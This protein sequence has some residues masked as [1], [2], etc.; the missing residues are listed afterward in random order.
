MSSV[1]SKPAGGLVVFFDHSMHLTA[2]IWKRGSKQTDEFFERLAA[3]D[4]T[5]GAR[6]KELDVVRQNLVRYFESSPA[7]YLVGIELHERLALLLNNPILL[8]MGDT[9]T[10]NGCSV[11]I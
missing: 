1:Y 6:A 2:Q 11:L 7:H 5:T 8:S 10:T 4:R 9:L 3:T